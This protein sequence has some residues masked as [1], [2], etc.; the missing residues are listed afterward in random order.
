MR[1]QRGFTLIELL[2]VIAIIGVLI[3]LLLPAV[4]AA[5]EA[6]RRSQ[7]TN[8]L[9]QIGLAVHNYISIHNSFMPGRPGNDTNNNDSNAA[10]GF[11]S[12]LAQMEG[13][14][15]YN[16]WNWNLLFNDPT[17]SG[18]VAV[19]C[20][21]AANSTVATT[22]MNIFLCPSDPSQPS[23]DLTGGYGGGRNDI[24]HTG[25][26]LAAVGSYAF[27]AGTGGPPNAGPPNGIYAV[28]DIKHTNNGIADYGPTRKIQDVT[29]G[30][31]TTLCV[32]ETAYNDGRYNV[33]GHA[34]DWPATQIYWNVWSINLRLGSCFRTTV[35]PLN[36]KPCRTGAAL[37]GNCQTAAFGSQHSGGANFLFC[38]GH[39]AFLKDSI[40]WNVYNFLATI[41]MGET[42]SSDSY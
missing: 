10:S 19:A 39:V 34:T 27:C 32:G 1:R 20:I 17:V 41:N 38:D 6:A 14:T 4:Q 3:A 42:I 9:K 25:L 18:N 12:L 8:N 29:D 28:S 33:P 31:S 15:L 7:C 37:A 2:V 21:P 35:N 40:N 26:Q 11:V 5:R 36:T 30:T 13:G 22:K 24:P 23:L 16:A